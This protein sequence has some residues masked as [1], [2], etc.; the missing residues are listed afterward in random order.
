MVP[1]CPD[2]IKYNAPMRRKNLVPL[3]VA[4]AAALVAVSCKSG[5]GGLA[6]TGSGEKVALQINLKKS[7]KLVYD[8]D[9]KITMNMMQ[10]NIDMT[11]KMQQEVEVTDKTDSGF[12]TKMTVKDISIKA[13]NMP[14]G[15]GMD[16]IAAQ[17][18][19]TVTDMSYD[20]LGNSL[21]SKTSS[22]NAMA[23]SLG[24]NMGASNVGF[25]G[26]VCPK[27]KVGV[28]AEWQSEVDLQK[29]LDK[30][31]GMSAKLKGK[32]KMPVKFKL[33]GFDTANGKKLA[34]IDVAS[35]GTIDADIAAGGKTQTISL[36]FKTMGKMKV[37]TQRGVI[38]EV[39]QDSTNETKVSGQTMTQKIGGTV[40]LKE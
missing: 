39:S 10:Q 17:M 19:G 35:D 32:S 2:K 23:E 22:N 7:D 31:A 21:S 24:S 1:R 34:L 38:V 6:S 5:G 33:T 11:M 29:M 30:A 9:F 25:M 40:K 12:K 27:D 14:G 28:G 16:A 4:A 15:A 26:L 3:F 20:N 36:T 8:T 37:D 13:P 18:K